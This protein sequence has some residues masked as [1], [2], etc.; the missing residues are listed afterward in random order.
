MAAEKPLKARK[1]IFKFWK[2]SNK[3]SSESSA[4]RKAAASARI[5][6]AYDET[7]DSYQSSELFLRV[8]SNEE[9]AQNVIPAAQ[10]GMLHM[11]LSYASDFLFDKNANL[12]SFVFEAHN[13]GQNAEVPVD[14]S[15]T[16]RIPLC[17]AS[18]SDIALVF[19]SASTNKLY[20]CSF[21]AQRILPQ[22][23]CV[24]NFC[25][26][27][28]ENDAVVGREITQSFEKTPIK[29]NFVVVKCFLEIYSQVTFSTRF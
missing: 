22:V 21:G 15:S 10:Y 11:E 4:A 26:P 6:N 16:L 5:S 18:K 17:D 9:Y 20:S 25:F 13:A 19:S 28:D 12:S 3:I 8:G 1:N 2:S 29:C 14:F 7:A 27:D 23:N 24:L